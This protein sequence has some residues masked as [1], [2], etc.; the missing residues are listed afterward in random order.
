MVGTIGGL[1]LARWR[2]FGARGTRGIR[3]RKE[4]R[5]MPYMR[6]YA[7]TTFL[8]WRKRSHFAASLCVESLIAVFQ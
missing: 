3:L 7:H 1:M 8:A 2:T 6:L 4:E 5:D